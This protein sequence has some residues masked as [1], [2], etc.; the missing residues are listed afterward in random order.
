V[1]GR[2]VIVLM[3]GISSRD[4]IRVVRVIIAGLTIVFVAPFPVGEAHP[5]A[6]LDEGLI[7]AQRG[8]HDNW[9]PEEDDND[10]PTPPS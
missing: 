1:I 3:L 4:A 2:A 7:V 9:D 8:P 5:D 6:T 10:A